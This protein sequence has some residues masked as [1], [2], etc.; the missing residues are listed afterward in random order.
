MNRRVKELSYRVIQ[1]SEFS[2]LQDDAEELHISLNGFD[3]VVN[4]QTLTATPTGDYAD[5]ADAHSTLQ[6]ALDA[7]SAT[8]EL[9]DMCPLD[10]EPSGHVYEQFGPVDPAQSAAYAGVAYATVAVLDVAAVA[11]NKLP[12]PHAAIR[13][14]DPVTA[15]LRRRWRN[16]VHGIESP[17]AVG[18]LVLT[19]IEKRYGGRRKA[20]QR[21]NIS[22]KVFERL[23]IISST[24]DP[25]RGR[26][27][28]KRAGVITDD[29]V[30]WI[31]YACPA[32]MRRVLEY[33][34]G[35]DISHTISNADLP[36]LPS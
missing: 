21:L 2:R 3:C 4:S 20:A 30:H 1:L 25:I 12:E 24:D 16:V 17:V 7:W 35:G 5:L 19:T 32:F 15:Q 8:S 9:I 13:S 10:F 27:A 34:A 6:P 28:S 23:G 33:E 29:E 36:P 11:R 18:Y 14:E 22:A 31:K 26:K